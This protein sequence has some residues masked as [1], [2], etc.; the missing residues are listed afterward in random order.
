MGPVVDLACVKF[1]PTENTNSLCRRINAKHDNF[2]NTTPCR[3]VYKNSVQGV[4]CSQ[5][6]DIPGSCKFISSCSFQVL[7]SHRS[8]ES[9]FRNSCFLPEN[10]RLSFYTDG[11]AIPCE[12]CMYL[13]SVCKI[14]RVRFFSF[15]LRT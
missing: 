5:P 15:V 9:V 4:N 3:S 2:F 13:C 11:L 12:L 8:L 14:R 1:K 7:R 10:F 6:Q